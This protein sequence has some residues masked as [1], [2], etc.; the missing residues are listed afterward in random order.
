MKERSSGK[1]TNIGI[2]MRLSA[3][4]EIIIFGVLVGMIILFSLPLKVNLFPQ[5]L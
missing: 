4:R 1:A 5:R 2:L 3:V